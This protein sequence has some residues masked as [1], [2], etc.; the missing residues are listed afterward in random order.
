M[1][2]GDLFQPPRAAAWLVTLFTPPKE[3]DSIVGDLL[4]EFSHLTSKSGIAV[5]RRWYW[6]QTVRTIAHLVGAG[7][8]GAPW[9]TAGAVVAGLLLIRFGFGLYSQ[10][11][12]AVL[13]RWV[14]EYLSDLGSQEPSLD[15]AAYMYWIN[16][17]RLVGRVL[18]AMVIGGV[19]GAAAKGR[20]MTTTISLGLFMSALGVALSLMGVA[21]NGDYEFLFLWAL[22]SVFAHSLPVVVGGAI[23][24][25]LRS[26][27]TTPPS[28]A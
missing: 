26:A 21:R 23:V 6:R 13:D 27:T 20:E 19:L 22:P 3:A 17:V 16:R 5:A 25:T 9:S 15:V 2:Q 1:T 12:E 18:V 7:F 14:Y 8:R 24:R 4:E 28:A 11:F 10:A